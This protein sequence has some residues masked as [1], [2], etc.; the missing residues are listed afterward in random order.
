MNRLNETEYAKARDLIDR[1]RELLL[2]EKAPEPTARYIFR[3][4]G[5]ASWPLIPSAFRADTILGYESQQFCR[6]SDGTPRRTWDQGNAELT[7]VMEFLQLADKVGLD[8]PADHEWL[9]PY[10]VWPGY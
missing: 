9:R 3:G 8:L 1:V 6:V 2:E 7:A 5:N 10:R 4:Q